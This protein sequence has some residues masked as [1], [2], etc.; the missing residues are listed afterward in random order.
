MRS[1]LPVIT[2]LLAGVVIALG[3]VLVLGGDDDE[4]GSSSTKTTAAKPE[5]ALK[6]GAEL[7]GPGDA[8]TLRYPK[9]GWQALTQKDLGQQ[10]TQGVAG[11]RRADGGAIVIVQERQ[12]KLGTKLEQL[13]DDLTKQLKKSIKDFRFVDSNPVT[14]PAG[15]A[16]SYTFLRT[17]SD[18]VQNLVVIPVGDRTYTLN[19]LIGGKQRD[20]AREVAAIVRSFEP[21]G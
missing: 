3:A 6:D 5:A 18:R 20:A 14:L 17:K 19:S 13:P 16:V 4:G 15:K 1:K 2:A 10:A 11:V 7:K 12:G 8:F 9:K 21:E